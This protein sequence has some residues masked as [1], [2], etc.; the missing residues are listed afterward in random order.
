MISACA[1]GSLGDVTPCHP[2]PPTSP[3][4]TI[5]QP[6]GPPLP[7]ST[8]SRASSIACCKNKISFS[9][10]I[11]A[12]LQYSL[13]HLKKQLQSKTADQKTFFPVPKQLLR[14]IHKPAIRNLPF[15]PIHL[16]I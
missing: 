6:K 2:F 8:P 16:D 7:A 11:K 4:R 3:F 10:I 9:V 1:V 14:P 5:T 15:L 13:L 12:K